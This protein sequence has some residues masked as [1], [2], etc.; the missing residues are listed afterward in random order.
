MQ[1]LKMLVATYGVPET[2]YCDLGSPYVGGSLKHAMLLLGS[3]YP[4]LAR[5][6][7]VRKAKLKK[8]CH[9]LQSI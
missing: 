5:K 2:L 4:I 6:I 8:L 9:G 7:Q 3:K 1:I